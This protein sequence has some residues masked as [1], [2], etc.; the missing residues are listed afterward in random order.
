MNIVEKLNQRFGITNA[1]SFIQLPNGFVE[2]EI[3]NS[4][5][6]AS[7]AMQGAHLMRFQPA[8]QQPLIWISPD[9]ILAQG[10]SIRGGVPVCWPWFG[11]HPEATTLPAHGFARMVPWRLNQV[12]SLPN[13]ET[14]LE[15]ELS[16]SAAIRRQWSQPCTLRNIITIGKTL[17]H[18][19]VTTNLDSKPMV[20]GEALHTYF[21]VGDIRHVT[22]CGLEGR[23]YLDKVTDFSRQTQTGPV[24]FHGEVDRIYLDPPSLCEI[25]DPLLQRRIVIRSRGSRSTV[26]WNPWREKA[27]QMGDMG[28]H[29]YRQMLCVETANAAGASVSLAP[30]EQHRLVAHYAIEAL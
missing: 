1:V 23:D 7:I 11:A 6:S 27:L 17:R 26:V 21:Q 16:S 25:R 3:N 22:I 15:F 28:P 24:K 8:G 29:G 9:A 18:E 19:L 10:K 2:V 13:G 5:A 12:H 14:R 30:G 20:I 4:H